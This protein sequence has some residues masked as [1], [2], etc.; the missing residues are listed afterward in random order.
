MKFI[1]T[2]AFLAA[3]FLA[4]YSSA[5]DK[6]SISSVTPVGM[7]VASVLG[8]A[9]EPKVQEIGERFARAMAEH[10][11]WL[12]GYVASQKDL[13]PGEP[14][15]YHKNFGVS[16]TEYKYFGENF[17]KSS[18]MVEVGK[19]EL[20]SEPQKSGTTLSL[21]AQNS[22]LRGV[23]VSF[24]DGIVQTQFGAMKDPKYVSHADGETPLGKWQGYVWSLEEG[25]PLSSSG[26]AKKIGLVLGV[27]EDSGKKFLQ[28]KAYVINQGMVTVREELNL[29]VDDAHNNSFKTDVPARPRP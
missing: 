29:L 18:R 28:Y 6:P 25:D 2:T 7:S 24:E 5:G 9:A 22:S 27:V 19:V 14:L 4:T 8:I 17:R 23:G 20:K 13:K 3:L 1:K 12:K 15:P 11:D 21:I 26:Q 10:Q 16:E